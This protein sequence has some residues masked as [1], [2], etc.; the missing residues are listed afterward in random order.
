MLLNDDEL[1]EIGLVEPFSVESLQEGVLSWGLSAFGYDIRLS[2]EEM[3]CFSKRNPIN[4]FRRLVIDPKNFTRERAKSFMTKLPLEKEG[5]DSY[6]L[7]PPFSYCLGVSMEYI[8]IP[9][10]TLSFTFNKSTY[11]RCGLSVPATVLEPEWEG[12]LT[13]ELNNETPFGIK[14]YA[15]EGICQLV[16]AKGNACKESYRKKGGKYMYQEQ[17]VVFPKIIHGKQH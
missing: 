12:Y 2:P 16:S 6:F 17:Q 13:L 8:K 10:N 15:E 14:V 5:K 7:I 9:N 11:A 3:L 4:L 1:Q